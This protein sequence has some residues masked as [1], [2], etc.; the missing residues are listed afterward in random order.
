[1]FKNKKGF[2]LIELVVAIVIMVILALA[3]TSRFGSYNTLRLASAARKTAAD[4]QY[5]QQLA[6]SDSTLVSAGQV[7]GSTAFTTKEWVLEFDTTTNTYT[8]YP[9]VWFFV[10][11][12]DNYFFDD[13]I[14]DP[15]T[16]DDFIVDLEE[17]GVSINSINCNGGGNDTIIFTTGNPPI[18]AQRQACSTPIGNLHCYGIRSPLTADATITLQY[19]ADLSTRNVTISETGRIQVQ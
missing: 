14:Q 11:S 2:S 13:P 12:G 18:C 19:D 3:A 9:N 8:L 16:K 1:M 5:A 7:D 4:L 15:Y 6:I 10:M 17:Y